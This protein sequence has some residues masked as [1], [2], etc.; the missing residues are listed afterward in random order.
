MIDAINWHKI[1]A[2]APTNMATCHMWICNGVFMRWCTTEKG[3]VSSHTFPGLDHWYYLYITKN[4]GILLQKKHICSFFFPE[5]NI[6]IQVYKYHA[7]TKLQ[8]V[9]FYSTGQL[10]LVMYNIWGAST[11]L[12]PKWYFS[13]VH[14]VIKMKM[15][16]NRQLGNVNILFYMQVCFLIRLACMWTH[17]NWIN[18]STCN[19]KFYQKIELQWYITAKQ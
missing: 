7:T 1:T 12:G 4:W 11:I 10:L 17:R 6:C 8:L 15:N 19:A 5:K 2:L 3:W 16:N 13:N 14:K 9:F 18:F